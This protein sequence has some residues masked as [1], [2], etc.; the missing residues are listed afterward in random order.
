VQLAE[1]AV[2]LP[3]IWHGRPSTEIEPMAASHWLTVT[4]NVLV[5]LVFVKLADAQ[6]PT[7]RTAKRQHVITSD[8]RC[9]KGSYG[10]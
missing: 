10:R 2:G 5:L 4:A 7:V 1:V 6:L 9:S 3:D 8:I